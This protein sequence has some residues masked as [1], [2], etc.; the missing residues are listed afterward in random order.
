MEKRFSGKVVLITGGGSGIGRAAAIA[1]AREGAKLVICDVF[2]DG[3]ETTVRQV[4]DVGGAAAFVPADVTQAA[5]IEA[6]VARAITLYGGLDY[7]LNSAGV[8][9]V[10]SRVPD[11]PEDQWNRVIGINLTGVFLSMKYEIPALLNR[12]RGAIVNMAS[13]AGV[14]GFSGHAGYAA[15]KHGVVGLTKTAAIEYAEKGIRINAICPAYTRTPMVERL[16]ESQPDF[17]EKLTARIPIGRMGTAEEIAAAVLYLC[18]DAAA[19][20]TGHSLVLDGGITAQ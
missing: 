20:M 17:E 5:E 8:E 3:G 4:A 11:Y 2:A 1:F 16:V 19:F 18:S 15:S 7:A 6:A 12:G 14:T 9:G 13:V 10:R